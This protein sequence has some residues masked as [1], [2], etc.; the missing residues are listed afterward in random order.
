MTFSRMSE[1]FGQWHDPITSQ[2]Y[3]LNFMSTADTE[4]FEQFFV[5]A[6]EDK[7]PGSGKPA[8]TAAAEPAAAAAPAVAET[9]EVTGNLAESQAAFNRTINEKNQQLA[10]AHNQISALQNEN[11]SLKNQ[12]AALKGE[13]NKSAS[14]S[15]DVIKVRSSCSLPFLVLTRAFRSGCPTTLPSSRRL[16]G[17]ARPTS[18]SGRHRSPST[19]TR[20][21]PCTQRSRR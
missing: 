6:T 2:F 1:T 15:T 19:S 14:G 5:D 4:Q 18:R 17:Q 8:G 12:V 13:V 10:D 9:S 21:A 7:R 20:T 11:E 3:G 16:S